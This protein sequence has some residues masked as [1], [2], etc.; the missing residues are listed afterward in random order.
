LLGLTDDELS[1]LE[2]AGIISRK[3]LGPMP[4]RGRLPRQF[5]MEDGYLEFI[6]LR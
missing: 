5:E 4:D 6:G 3:L 1:D 2:E